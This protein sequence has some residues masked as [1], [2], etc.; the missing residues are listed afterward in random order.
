MQPTSTAL[1]S[2]PQTLGAFDNGG[3]DGNAA[4]CARSNLIFLTLPQV[5]T[6]SGSW[7]VT[8]QGSLKTGLGH[9]SSG[10]FILF[11]TTNH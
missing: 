3:Q 10:S 1:T 5:R 4:I 8:L 6:A 7:F 2:L 11:V 9:L